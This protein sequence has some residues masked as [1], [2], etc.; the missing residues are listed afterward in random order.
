LGLVQL[1][2]APEQADAARDFMRRW[3]AGEMA[4]PDEEP[5]PRPVRRQPEVPRI[6]P[7]QALLGLLA[8]GLLGFLAAKLLA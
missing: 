1:R 5:P 2:V 8:L 7:E 6:K 4:L 3:A